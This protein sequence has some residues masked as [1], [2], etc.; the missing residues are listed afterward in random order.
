MV[1]LRDLCDP[2]GRNLPLVGRTQS[3]LLHA[4]DA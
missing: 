2:D 4:A 1:A 3:L